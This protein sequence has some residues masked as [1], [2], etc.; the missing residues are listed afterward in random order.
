MVIFFTPN[1]FV[2][3]LCTH[4]L[5]FL[6]NLACILFFSKF[7]LSITFHAI[8]LSAVALAMIT[9]LSILAWRWLLKISLSNLS[10]LLSFRADSGGRFHNLRN[11][12]ERRQ[13]VAPEIFDD[14]ILHSENWIVI[15][16]PDAEAILS[17]PR[18]VDNIVI[19]GLGLADA[20]V[21]ARLDA[22]GFLL[23]LVCFCGHAHIALASSP[24][25]GTSCRG[26]GRPAWCDWPDGRPQDGRVWA[27]GLIGGG[28]SCKGLI[29][30]LNPQ[31]LPQRRDSARL[32]R[33]SIC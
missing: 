26:L 11:Q 10:I 27:A 30:V 19:F 17:M 5:F 13:R 28:R 21:L 3:H 18:P 29:C 25:C 20:I 24:F 15:G 16:G 9:F 14:K 32:S 4:L 22:L 8:S 31:V 1:T 7:S 6:C 12:R 23:R 33:S 2:Y